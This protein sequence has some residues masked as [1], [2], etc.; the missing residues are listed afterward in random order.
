MGKTRDRPV[1]VK[2]EKRDRPVRVQWEGEKKDR[3]VRVKWGGK[4][5]RPVRVKC[6]KNGSTGNS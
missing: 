3:P 4:R 2:Y 1:R 5:H 6:Q